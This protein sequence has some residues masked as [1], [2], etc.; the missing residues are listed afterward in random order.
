MCDTSKADALLVLETFDS[1]SDVLGS[2][3]N[4]QVNAILN[5]VPPP[6]PLKQ[7]RMNVVGSWRLYDPYNQKIIDQY[8]STSFLTFDA[9]AGIIAIPPPDALPKTAYH[10]GAEYVQRF[11]PQYYYVKRDMY[12]R[13]KGKEK[14]EFLRAFRRSEMS[15]WEEAVEVWKPLTKS[16][17]R[18]NAG[19]A[20]LNM[21]VANEVL[22]NVEVALS[23]A[24]EAY[25]DYGDKIAK[26]YQGYLKYRLQV[27]Y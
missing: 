7:I 22:G 15:K 24:Q 11:F 10:A 18:K 3:V 5:G 27:E 1:N 17:N 6:P 19:R 9:G 12:K 25:V 8:Q 14:Q 4:Q 26:E 13:G 16:S 23:W 21:A 2:A 20:C